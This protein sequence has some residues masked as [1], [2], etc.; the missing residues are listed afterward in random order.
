MT[1][2]FVEILHLDLNRWCV[3]GNATGYLQSL[4]VRG[5]RRKFVFLTDVLFMD[6]ATIVDDISTLG[7][8][9]SGYD[10]F[11]KRLLSFVLVCIGV[12]SAAIQYS[13]YHGRVIKRR[14]ATVTRIPQTNWR[15]RSC[16][17]LWS[18]DQ[19]GDPDG[20]PKNLK[21]V[22]NNLLTFR[23]GRGRW[24]IT[25]EPTRFWRPRFISQP[26]ADAPVLLP[27]LLSGL[28]WR[29]RELSWKAPLAWR[30]C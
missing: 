24:A 8:R 17:L 19:F 10:I 30:Q 1:S 22:K 27:T 21:R 20:H 29:S 4:L 12:F 18:A 15:K 9:H 23:V 3:F 2:S 13:Q 6:L 11:T 25:M 14:H 28:L 16:P 5:T 7:L 26:G